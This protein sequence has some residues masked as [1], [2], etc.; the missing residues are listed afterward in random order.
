MRKEPR[1]ARSRVTIEAILD[2]SAHILGERGSAG[3]T[4]NAVAEKA[5]VSIGSLYQYFPDKRVL[6]DAVRRR[7]LD[8]L[9]S[10]LR[11]ASDASKDRSSRVATFVDGMIAIHRR[12]PAAHQV[13]LAH[14]SEEDGSDRLNALFEQEYREAYEGLFMANKAMEVPDP[15]SAATILAA[16]VA[17]A[18]HEGARRDM[19]G[20]PAF[21]A[22]LLMLIDAYL[23]RTGA[24][25]SEAE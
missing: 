21:R 24:A 22:E 2:A 20:S 16:A 6:V 4:T 9:L 3:F 19:L 23:S 18:V 15:R 11:A 14:A 12:F 1:Q 17:G 5:G 10:V 8:E 25:Q 13:L 7:H